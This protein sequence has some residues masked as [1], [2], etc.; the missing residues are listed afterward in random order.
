MPPSVCHVVR[1]LTDRCCRPGCPAE[2]A[3]RIWADGFARHSDLDRLSVA[4]CH[5][6]CSAIMSC[7][8]D[9]SCVVRHRL[10]RIL[11][12]L[13][14]YR[15][16]PK[17]DVDRCSDRRVPHRCC[18]ARESAWQAVI[19]RSGTA[20]PCCAWP[21]AVFRTSRSVPAAT[22]AGRVTSAGWLWRPAS[23]NPGIDRGAVPNDGSDSLTLNCGGVAGQPVCQRP[24][25][26][27]VPSTTWRRSMSFCNFPVG[28]CGSSLANAIASGRHHF[29]T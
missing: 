13:A 2:S 17:A 22:R 14:K 29:G 4:S 28:P 18:C 15:V 1:C 7:S 12:R 27:I 9:F 10:S 5:C 21:I 24:V 16:H 19:A 23:R 20:A 26:T 6:V 11:K 25:G 8:V 3:H